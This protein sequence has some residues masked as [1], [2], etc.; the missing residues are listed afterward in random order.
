MLKQVHARLGDAFFMNAQSKGGDTKDF[1]SALKHYCRSVELCEGFL[2]G[3]YGVKLV[4][5]FTELMIV[6]IAQVR[7]V[8]GSARDRLG[9]I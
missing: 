6:S 4:G 8:I 7:V 2:R 1:A 9:W 5:V 3:W